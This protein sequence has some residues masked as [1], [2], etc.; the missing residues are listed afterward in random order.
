MATGKPPL[1]L[2]IKLVAPAESAI[3]LKVVMEVGD[4]AVQSGDSEESVRQES[5]QFVLRSEA[6][7]QSTRMVKKVYISLT[8]FPHVGTGSNIMRNVA[9][10]ILQF[11]KSFG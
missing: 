7:S 5:T 6:R 8:S 10:S 11:R 4:E 2:Q 3:G 9:R 1:S